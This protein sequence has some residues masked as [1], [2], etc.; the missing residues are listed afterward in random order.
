[1]LETD[2]LMIFYGMIVFTHLHYYKL[3]EIFDSL[4]I[5]EKFLRLYFHP[6]PSCVTIVGSLFRHSPFFL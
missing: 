2:F 6:T 3:V 1:M 5:K 4:R